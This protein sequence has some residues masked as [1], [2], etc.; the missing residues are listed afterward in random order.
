MWWWKDLTDVCRRWRCIIFAS[1]HFLDLQLRCTERTP[2]RTSLNIWPP[3]PI[4]VS[5]D[6]WWWDDDNI[7]AALEHHDRVIRINLRRFP[8]KLSAVTQK[9]FPVLKRFYLRSSD[10]I[11]PVLHEG[12]LGGSTPRLRRFSLYN[13]GFP[14]FPKLALSCSSLSHLALRRIPIAGYISPEAMATCLATL[15][16]LR[17]LY[18]EFEFP[19]TRPDRIG[20][21]PPTRIVL[22]ALKYFEFRG[23]GEYWEDLTA[24]IDIPKPLKLLDYNSA[25]DESYVRYSTRVICDSNQY[26]SL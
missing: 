21:P 3:F 2:T 20:F 11:A 25:L 22:P 7:I 17:Y 10:E 15:P 23:V 1:P 5:S 16:N 4:V 9:P 8:A 14:A 6:P 13:I 19:Q 18:I 26:A 12:F 24:R